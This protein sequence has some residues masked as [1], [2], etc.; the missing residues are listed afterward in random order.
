[1]FEIWVVKYFSLKW[2]SCKSYI[3]L[4]EGRLGATIFDQLKQ[5]NLHF[6]DALRWAVL[7]EKDGRSQSSLGFVFSDF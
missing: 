1:M 7:A 5:Y 2:T 6:G 3:D 4:V